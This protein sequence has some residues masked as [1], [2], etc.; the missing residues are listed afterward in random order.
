[1]KRRTVTANP[2]DN[3]RVHEI[4]PDDP[5][6]LDEEPLTPYEMEVKE[7]WE[8]FWPEPVHQ[9]TAQGPIALDEAIRR[10][11]HREEY[12]I[13]L[14]LA[15]NPNLHRDQVAELFRD[16]VFLPPED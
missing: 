13:S 8:R 6:S 1:M 10:A 9:L 3:R 16:E 5:L 14:T 11:T 15:R 7:H 12:M 2:P 4:D